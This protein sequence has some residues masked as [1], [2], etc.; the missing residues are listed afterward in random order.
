MKRPLGV[1]PSLVLCCQLQWFRLDTRS[2][3][4]GTKVYN[5]GDKIVFSGS[6]WET[7][8]AC[9]W[10]IEVPVLDLLD[11]LASQKFSFIQQL[12]KGVFGKGSFRNLRAEL[13]FCVF[14]CVLRWFSPA[15]LTEISFRNCPSSAGIF[16]KTPLA[17]NPKTQL[18]T[19]CLLSRRILWICEYFFRV[20]LGNLHWKMAGIFGE[21]FLVSISHETKHEKS[22]KNSGKIRSKIRGKFGTKYR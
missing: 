1:A 17:K 14:F 18:L 7:P 8:L 19:I 12:K 21:F 3:L 20:C 22:S 6:N 5:T 16:W 2:C 10:A 13:L 4:I 11:C 15:N 9:G